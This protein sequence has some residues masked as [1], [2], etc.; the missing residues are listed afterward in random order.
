MYVTQANACTAPNSANPPTQADIMRVARSMGA[1]EGK[2]RKALQAFNCLLYRGDLNTN[3]WDLATFGGT[4]ASTVSGCPSV[5][6]PDT[7][8]AIPSTPVTEPTS[9]VNLVGLMTWPRRMHTI[10]RHQALPPNSQQAYPQPPAPPM[11]PLTTQAH[12]AASSQPATAVTTPAA[13]TPTPLGTSQAQ[14]AGIPGGI[15][16]LA[17]MGA[18]GQQCQALSANPA[19]L[20]QCLA[21]YFPGQSFGTTNAPTPNTVNASAG[22]PVGIPT[23][24]TVPLNLPS[25]LGVGDFDSCSFMTGLI[26]AVGLAAAAWYLYKEYEKGAFA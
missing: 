6:T 25:P 22:Q 8:I 12:S 18:M 9:G 3:G 7:A 4:P 21:K 24:N 10:P 23:P 26:G 11:Q 16:N 2:V 1:M 5:N 20:K 15:P 13:P 14:A 19:L 17:V